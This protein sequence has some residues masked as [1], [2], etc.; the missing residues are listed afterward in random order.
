MKQNFNIEMKFLHIK[1]TDK[2]LNNA[3]SWIL[4]AS[5]CNHDLKFIATSNKNSKSSI[6][7]IMDKHHKNIYLH[8]TYLLSFANCSTKTKIIN[9]KSNNNYNS[10]DKNQRFFICCLHIIGSQ[11]KI[12][13]IGANIYLL[14]LLDHITNHDFIYIPLG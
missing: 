12:L 1:R 5:N 6:Y 14:N 8:F 4:L 7:Y 3:N 13:I 2:W 9:E 11:W 10:I